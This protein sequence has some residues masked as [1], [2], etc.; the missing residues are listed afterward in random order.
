MKISGFTFIKNA[1]IYDFPVVE[2]I[3][4]AL[5]LVDEMIVVVGQSDDPTR[6]LIGSINS[7][8]IRIIDTVWDM[9][10]FSYGG[11]IFAQQTD[12]ALHACTGDWCVYLQSDEVLHQDALPVIRA[13][14]EKYLHDDRIEGMRLDYVH[15]Y[16]DYQ[17]YIDAKHMGYPCEVRVVRGHRADI[18]SWLDAQSFRVIPDFDGV[19]YLDKK[20]SR[21]LRC[22]ALKG[23]FMFHY[24]W[25]RDP[26]A[27]AG[28]IK[29]QSIAH[30]PTAQLRQGVDYYDY[31]NLSLFPKYEG[32]QPEVMRERIDT[33]NWG[34]LLRYDGAPPPFRKKFKAKY[35]LINF[36]EKMVGGTF[37]IGGFKNYEIVEKFRLKNS[38]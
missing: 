13:A 16:G 7:N 10:R 27:M 11:M 35:R 31:G 9:E 5:P 36:I 17:R 28:K 22:V 1:V 14:C 29:A 4:S 8:K 26:R 2:S 20:G 23:A 38:K 6:E 34:D 37:R 30:D 24:G 15:I 12:V 19:S 32:T 25:S 33:I 18:H 21:L 3:L